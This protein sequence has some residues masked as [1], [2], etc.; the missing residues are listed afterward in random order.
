MK[1]DEL[2]FSVGG[3]TVR[4]KGVD[5]TV[6]EATQAFKLGERITELERENNQ[7]RARAPDQ[8]PRTFGE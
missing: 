8:P 2:E 3:V 6:E 5:L 7:L 4:V 1:V